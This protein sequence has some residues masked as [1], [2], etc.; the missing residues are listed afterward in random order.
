MPCG[1]YSNCQ[2]HKSIFTHI[3]EIIIYNSNTIFMQTIV[4]AVRWTRKHSDMLAICEKTTYVIIHLTACQMNL[5][6]YGKSSSKRK[7]S[8]IFIMVL[9]LNNTCF[10]FLPNHFHWNTNKP[11]PACWVCHLRIFISL[12]VSK[13]PLHPPFSVYTVLLTMLY[14]LHRTGSDK[15]VRRL[16]HTIELSH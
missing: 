15:F 14:K 9:Q 6:N 3:K 13:L 4:G 1:V 12:S 8:H 11:T 10:A 16:S 5:L 2:H 7:F